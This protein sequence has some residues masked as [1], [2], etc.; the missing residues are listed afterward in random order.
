MSRFRQAFDNFFE[1]IKY[2]GVESEG[3][4]KKIQFEKNGKVITI[5]QLST[6]EK[7]IVY[8]GIFLLRNVGKLDGA[9][10]MIDEP[11][12][13]MHPKWQKRIMHYFMDL[14]KAPDGSQK[15]QIFFATHS[16]YVLEEALRDVDHTL[17]VVLKD[18]NGT[19][20]GKEIR[21][22]LVLP[23][24]TASEINYAAFGIPSID[25]H[26]ALYGAIQVKY[27]KPSIVGCDQFIHTQCAPYYD[28]AVHECMTNYGNN[29]YHTL[30]T[31]IRNHIDHPNNHNSFTNEEL[32]TS[33]VLMRKILQN[34]PVAP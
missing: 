16:E 4:E 21:T 20:E 23:T 28:T 33:I 9:T 27:N 15:A 34:I 3:G 11:E 26:I 8:R 22:P 24:L 19:I 32:E 18:N 14:F 30:C 31:K 17:V 1:L 12:L 13:S 25:Y 7:Q 6:G 5:D 2:R 29:T 10:I